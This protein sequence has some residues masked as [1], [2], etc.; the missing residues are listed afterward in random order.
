LNKKFV[1]RPLS[2]GNSIPRLETSHRFQI[3][4]PIPTKEYKFIN[5][6]IDTLGKFLYNSK[7]YW[8]GTLSIIHKAHK[9]WEE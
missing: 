6:F 7:L 2:L 8:C 1:L 3:F 9:E 5:I 4:H